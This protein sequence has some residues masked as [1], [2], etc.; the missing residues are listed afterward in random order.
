MLALATGRGRASTYLLQVR[1]AEGELI[2]LVTNGRELRFSA[3]LAIGDADP[4]LIYKENGAGIT[5]AADQAGAGR[6]LAELRL[7]PADTAAIGDGERA[8]FLDCQLELVI[9]AGEPE[10][11]DSGVLGVYPVV[12]IATA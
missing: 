12:R 11:V 8:V 1:D 7:V 6:G 5:P 4:P 2:D 9:V 3:K 10:V